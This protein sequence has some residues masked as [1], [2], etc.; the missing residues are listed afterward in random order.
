M[1]EILDDILALVLHGDLG[2]EY[3]TG[4]KG[5]FPFDLPDSAE[6][7]EKNENDEER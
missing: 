2:A 3:V 1:D 5:N 7:E 6:T 4:K